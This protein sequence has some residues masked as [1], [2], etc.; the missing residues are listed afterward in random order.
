ML[1]NIFWTRDL[2]NNK[3]ALIEV[4]EID[5]IN[6]RFYVRKKVIQNG[7]KFMEN[8]R[9]VLDISTEKPEKTANFQKVYK[10]WAALSN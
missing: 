5:E 4:K 3:P 7:G 9:C 6:R 8:A 1:K 10:M 2:W